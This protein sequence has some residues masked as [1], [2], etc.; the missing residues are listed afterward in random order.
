M[1]RRRFLAGGAGVLGL[2]S[3]GGCLGSIQGDSREP[4]GFGVVAPLSGSLERIGTHCK[5]AVEQ[6]VDDI[7]DAGGVLDRPVE[8]VAV[9]SGASVES[10]VSAYES[11]RDEGVVGFVG[12]VISDVSIAL[13][14]KAAEDGLMEVSPASTSPA[15][16]GAGVNGDR[17]F[18]GRTVP[19]DLLQ[20]V[21]MAKVF[22]DARY[23]DADRVSFVYIDNSYGS[24]LTE[25]LRENVSAS[26]VAEVPYDPAADDFAPVVEEAFADDPD[27]VG[28]I[29]VPG[30]EKEVLDAYAAS[31][32]EAPW[33]FSSGLVPDSIPSFYDG[34]YSASLSSVRT[35]GYL[36]LTKK[37]SELDPIAPYAVN[38]YDAL[39]LM[40][41]A[42][43]RAGEASG[44]AIS[45]SIREVSGGTGHTFSVGEFD[46]ARTLLS[47]DREVNYQGAASD[48]DLNDHLEP[49]SP[50]VVE[51]V[52]DGGVRQ[53]ELLQKGYF[54][55]ESR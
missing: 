41:A 39:V 6:A 48:V 30:Q 12:G 49:L 44:E 46:R 32:H 18:F 8:L 4:V 13:A 25:A 38:G 29:S 14:P 33:V 24:G 11:M 17:T 40:A 19:S 36:S 47:S 2:G 52:V 28:Y 20:S 45:E 31:D 7:N 27:A 23:A 42:A 3:L 1:S 37:L 50:Y 55:G 9:D 53:L 34:F 26:V 51:R 15:L 22:D 21:V 54:G 16:T 43:E 35:N 10:A 5:R